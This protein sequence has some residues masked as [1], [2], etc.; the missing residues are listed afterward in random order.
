MIR[1]FEKRLNDQ[2][3]SASLQEVL[4]GFDKEAEWMRLA[5]AMQPTKKSIG[6]KPLLRAAAVLGF[7]VGSLWL[8]YLL[9]N[10]PVAPTKAVVTNATPFSA[11]SYNDYAKAGYHPEQVQMTITKLEQTKSAGHGLATGAKQTG[12][13]D[14]TQPSPAL[15]GK[16][17][18][19]RPANGMRGWNNQAP[20]L[21]KAYICNSTPCPVQ[22]CISQ[23]MKCKGKQPAAISTSSVLEPDQS[24]RLSLK[25]HGRIA[26]DCSITVNEIEIKSLNTGETIILNANS[27]PATAQEV[28]SY[29]T[30]Q[31][32][33]D[34]LAG[35]FRTDCDNHPGTNAIRFDNKFGD[36]IL[37]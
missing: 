5:H 20:M 30:G 21:A 12:I 9:Q 25:P 35:A 6:F 22:I 24:G 15:A 1:P 13:S 19:N 11:S 2:L 27:T 23:T 18:S 34:V 17:R 14:T 8:A 37:Q 26:K 10:Q 32:R 4:P 3:S 31:K 33:G 28:Y 7:V 16:I 36:L 29:I